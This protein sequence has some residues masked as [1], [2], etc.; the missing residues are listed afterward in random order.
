MVM[1]VKQS[2]TLNQS[3]TSHQLLK[4]RHEIFTHFRAFSERHEWY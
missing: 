4:G 1:M 3:E 2:T